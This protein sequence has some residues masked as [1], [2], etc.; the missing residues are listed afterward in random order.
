MTLSIGDG[1][2]D[3]TMIQEAHVGI[4]VIGLEGM[5]AV[6]AADYAIAQFRFLQQLLFVH[7]RWNYRRV[8]QVILYSFYK[9]IALVM[10]LFYFEFDNGYSGTT[11][12]ESWIGAGWNVGWTFLPILAVGVLDKDISKGSVLKYPAVYRSGQLNASFSAAKIIQVRVAVGLM[13]APCAAARFYAPSLG[14]CC[15]AGAHS[16][17]QTVSCMHL[18]CTSACTAACWRLLVTRAAWMAACG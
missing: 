5:Q 7:G 13:G 9:N 17:L 10:T 15:G 18:S 3:V 16:G 12:F 2:N 6:Q 11:L 1:G 14:C 8:A 4:G